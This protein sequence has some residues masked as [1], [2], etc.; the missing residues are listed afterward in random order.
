MG[1][2]TQLLNQIKPAI[3]GYKSNPDLML[4]ETA[5]NNVRITIADI[6]KESPGISELVKNRSVKIVGAFY[7]I[8][9]GQ[10]SFIE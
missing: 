8:A 3:T 4:D 10:V 7:D 9:S 1:N 5:K 2:L 6:L